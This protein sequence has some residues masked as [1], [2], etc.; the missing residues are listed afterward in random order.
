MGS[1]SIEVRIGTTNNTGNVLFRTVAV[2]VPPG[3]NLLANVKFEVRQLFTR[4][5]LSAFGLFDV[6]SEI[7]IFSL[8]VVTCGLMPFNPVTC[9]IPHCADS[10][11]L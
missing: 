7:Q 11:R 5:A 8:L 2:S 9:Y 3:V 6:S 10:P 4:P 1:S